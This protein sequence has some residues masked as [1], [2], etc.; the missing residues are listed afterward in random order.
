M[1][2]S[3]AT[4]SGFTA[5]SRVLGFL[6]DM[7]IVQYLG[8]G[9]VSDAFF[10][11]FRFPNLFRRVFGEGAFNSA[12][13]PLFAR[14]L[15]ENGKP[16][17][18]QFAS[19]TFTILALFLGAGTLIGLP[20]M[21]WIMSAVVPGFKAAD[22]SPAMSAGDTHEFRLNVKGARSVFFVLEG[23]SADAL[24][25]VE[26]GALSAEAAQ[27][28]LLASY[29]QAVSK[30]M[31]VEGGVVANMNLLDV[32][33]GAAGN[34]V[35]QGGAMMEV[36]L[37]DKHKFTQL[38]GTF[39]IEQGSGVHLKT[40]RNHPGTFDLTVKLTRITFAY[41][42]CMALVAHLSGV[43][44]TVKIFGMP[45]AAPVLLNVVF[46]IGLLVA[47]PV[48]GWKKDPVAC[49]YVAAVCVFVAGFVQLTALYVTCRMKGLPI[50]FIRPTITPR[51]KRLFVLMGPGIVSAGI[52]QINLLIGGIVAS[53]QE[54]AV[55]YLY[56]SDRI[57]QLPLGMIGIALGVVLLP[58]ITRR[59]RADDLAGARNSMNRGIEI[60]LLITFPAAIAMLVIPYP[61][62][63]TLF[64]RGEFKS[65]AS[66][67][68]A[69]AL[70]GFAIGLPGYVLIRVLQ[71][72]YFAQEN[73][74]SPMFMAGITV[75]VNIVCSL[76]LFPIFRHVGIAVATTISAWVNVFLLFRGLKGFLVIDQ[77]L[78]SRLPRIFFASVLMGAVLVGLNRVIDG[79]FV[80]SAFT[81]KAS[82][83]AILVFGGIGV[84]AG[85]VLALKATTLSDLK[86]GFRR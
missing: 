65:F 28:G 71:P 25:R 53:F 27:G 3:M 77:R 56:T 17:A 64:E 10:S 13:V 74:K 67:Q 80:E 5:I 29:Q 75:A 54:G 21:A 45:A 49:G 72:G 11:A 38:V 35:G 69:L 1:L 59:L 14:E 19:R 2:R 4:V 9:M 30:L 46:L 63:S 24:G 47:V 34:Q 83:L 76:L 43:L 58:E 31:G 52:Q 70:A 85:S 12:F 86:G 57:Y 6:R 39:K 32:S 82:G 16:Q 20:L 81:L 40:Y 73:T 33:N 8:A 60:A 61:I 62:V 48:M 41:L 66:E 84:Y 42:M 18:L 51:V 50:R 7:L 55:S 26:Q 22:T 44:N 68:T 79:W 78:K 15:Q 23:G 37:P 36:V